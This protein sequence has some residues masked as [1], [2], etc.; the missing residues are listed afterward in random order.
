MR[1][2]TPPLA[3]EG[4]VEYYDSAWGGFR[5]IDSFGDAPTAVF[6]RRKA[7]AVAK[8]RSQSASMEFRVVEPDTGERAERIVRYR[9]GK[10][11]G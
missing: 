10:R 7:H 9:R 5:R 1:M 4:R 2:S 6:P 8:E 3:A 11:L